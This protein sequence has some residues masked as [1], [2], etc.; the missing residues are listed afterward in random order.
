M[1]SSLGIYIDKNLIKYAKIKKKNNSYKVE[2]FKVDIFED[3]EDAIHK[4]VSE[5]NSY[6]IPISI[7]ISNEVYNYFEVF[8]ELEKK[9]IIKSLDIEFEK[10]C[11]KEKID[12]SFYESRYLLTENNNDFEKLNAIYVSIPKKEYEI[13]YEAVSDYKLF[14]MAPIATSIT[15]L[16]DVHNDK[17]VAIINIENDAKVTTIIDG[18]I[19]R[20]YSLESNLSYIA[21]NINELEMSWRKTYDV[22]KNI[23]IYNHDVKVITE[24]DNEYIDVVLPALDS[25]LSESKNILKK[26]KNRID[27]V[28]ISGIA[29]TINNIDLY[30]QDNLK[31]DCEILK[32]FFINS[33][34]LKLPI[35]EYIE[36]NSAIALALDGIDYIN[37]DLN[38]AQASTLDNIENMVNTA[39]EFSFKDWKEYIKGPYD[40]YEK[41]ILRA[42][43]AFLLAVI[44]FIIFSLNIGKQIEKQT[45]IINTNLGDV[46]SKIQ[47][48]DKQT[49][50]LKNKI[51]IY[52]AIINN[53]PFEKSRIISKDSIPNLLNKI[54]FIIPGEVQL[55]L[56]K[57]TEKNHIEIEAISLTKEDLQNFFESIKSDGMLKNMEMN[58]LDSA[59]NYKVLIEGDFN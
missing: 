8:S 41:L 22:F 56:V 16:L 33:N 6:R 39:S 13:K 19:D 26:Y 17:N 30:F 32:P 40:I 54:M 58:Y 11:N 1:A 14:S 46:Q 31:I 4:A 5:T 37:K 12:K 7:N 9:D 36:V 29:A 25:I 55:T 50:I 3:L 59:D 2:A 49:E 35:K 23:T 44:C 47:K 24:N 43:M 53:K 21:D 57:N 27:K 20:I 10:V 45:N 51:S 38:F 48:I 52:D 42:I 34:L 15:N 18:Q 28:Y